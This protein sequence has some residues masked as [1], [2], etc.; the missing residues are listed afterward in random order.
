MS[1]FILN[2]AGVQWLAQL[3]SMRQAISELNLGKQNGLIQGY[4]Q[5]I[6]VDDEDSSGGYPRGIWDIS[7]DK[8]EYDSGNSNS[9]DRIENE[10]YHRHFNYNLEW[11]RNQC[12]AFAKRKS[13]LE[14]SQIQ[15]Q[16]SALLASDM[17][18]AIS[19]LSKLI[20]D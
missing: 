13:G 6:V 4:G 20:V 15:R 14:A 2:T 16:L 5:N 11:L 12:I 19:H 10:Q 17:K 18:G 1:P 9:L 8:N 7:T 3:A